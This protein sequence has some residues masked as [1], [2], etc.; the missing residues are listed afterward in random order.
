MTSAFRN[1]WSKNQKWID[2]KA[3]SMLPYKA[4]MLKATVAVAINFLL[5]I[6][7]FPK[8]AIDNLDHIFSEVFPAYT[9]TS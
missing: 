9:L 7:E 1:M 4:V 3:K 2:K 6:K 5:E 8:E